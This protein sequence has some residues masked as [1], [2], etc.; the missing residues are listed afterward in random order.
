MTKVLLSSLILFLLCGLNVSI[1][2]SGTIATDGVYVPRLTTAQRNG[3]ATPTNGQMIYNTDDDC[4]NIYQK[5]AWQKLCGYNMEVSHSDDWVKKGDFSGTARQGAFGFSINTKGYIGTGGASASPTLS[6]F[7]EYNPTTD[8]WT[9]KANFGGG[10]RNSAVG[11]SIGNKGYVGTGSGSGSVSKED[12]WEYNPTTNVWTQKANVGG[13]VRT[14]AV[15]FSMG[16]KGYIGT[17][18]NKEDFWE[19]DTTANVWTQKANVGGGVRSSA[20]GFTIAD[21]AYIGTG[22]ASNIRK[23]DFWEYDPTANTW[24]QKANFLIFEAVPVPI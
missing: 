20:A 13:G 14:S 7:W 23:T 8:A 3:I 17:G 19:Y 24:T 18:T 5:D 16:N 11:F 21:K 2:Q 10:I 22:T 6:D 1:A 9:Q 15:G 4:F 12:F